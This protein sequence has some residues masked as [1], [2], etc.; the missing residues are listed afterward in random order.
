MDGSLLPIP[1]V[2]GASQWRTLTGTVA[3]GG[4]IGEVDELPCGAG[5]DL[6]SKKNIA[7]AL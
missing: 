6:Q 7:I 3:R 1:E 2:C 5:K 4:R